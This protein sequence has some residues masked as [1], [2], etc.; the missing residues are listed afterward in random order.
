[1]ISIHIN[2]P[3]KSEVS[4]VI[5][6]ISSF[7]LNNH[8]HFPTYISGN[9]LDLIITRFD[10]DLVRLCDADFRYPGSNRLITT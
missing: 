3:E 6:L 4:N 10:E 1:M 5:T 9:T 8:V 7:G 2:K